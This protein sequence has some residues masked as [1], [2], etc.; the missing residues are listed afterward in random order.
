MST[1]NKEIR[2]ALISNGMKQYHLANLLGISEQK[3]S[4][5]MRQEMDEERKNLCLEAIRKA[6]E[7]DAGN[8][9]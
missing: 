5:W 9:S 2:V 7:H 6:V 8:N 4:V 1:T 3:L